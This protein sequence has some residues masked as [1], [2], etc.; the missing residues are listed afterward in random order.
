VPPVAG[1]T[2]GAMVCPKADV[3]TAAANVNSKRKSRPRARMISSLSPSSSGGTAGYFRSKTGAAHDETAG[4][5][6]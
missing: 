4:L 2:A 6:K 1:P 3:V 5:S